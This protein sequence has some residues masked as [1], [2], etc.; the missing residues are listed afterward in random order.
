MAL[1]GLLVSVR[2]NGGEPVE[3]S[4]P[5]E[6][7]AQCDVDTIAN[8]DFDFEEWFSAPEIH[9]IEDETGTLIACDYEDHVPD[10]DDL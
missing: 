3:A 4:S 5:Q 8:S 6:A 7:L 9:R 1:I 2:E 10:I